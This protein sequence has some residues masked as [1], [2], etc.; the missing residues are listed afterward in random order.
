MSGYFAVHS[1]TKLFITRVLLSSTLLWGCSLNPVISQAPLAAQTVSASKRIQP[2]LAAPFANFYSVVDLGVAPIP[3]PLGDDSSAGLMFWPNNPNLLVIG[4]PAGKPKAG[5]YLIPVIRNI[6]NRIIGFG[7][8]FRHLNTPGLRN[9]GIDAGLTASPDGSVLFYTTYPDNGLGQIRLYGPNFPNP[10]QLI[11]LTSLGIAPSAGGVNFVPPG[12]PGAGRLKITSYNSDIV[13]DTT[14]SWNILSGVFNIAR[15]SSSVTLSGGI[16]T[17]TYIRAGNPGFAQHSM[18]VTEFN[19]HKISA[20]QLDAVGNPVPQTRQDFLLSAG[21]PSN[22]PYS[23]LSAVTDP[24]TGDLLISTWN[25]G[26]SQILAV[27][28]FTRL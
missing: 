13:Y 28:G 2:Q 10:N 12:F 25:N 1:Q 15:P 17:I 8:S 11:D 22:A 20:Y 24:L 18:L 9:G 27:R 21:N 7:P 14:V 5:L 6:S 23:V 4:G 26:K 19:T 3:Q 16:D